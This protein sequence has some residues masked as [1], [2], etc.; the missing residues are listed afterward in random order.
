MLDRDGVINHDSPDYIK[1]ADDWY[2][3]DGSIDRCQTLPAGIV[4]CIAT[5]Q[6]GIGRG[7][8]TEDLES[9]TSASSKG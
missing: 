8:F 2:P 5:N 1:H 6:A 3:I 9:I 4:V 7:L